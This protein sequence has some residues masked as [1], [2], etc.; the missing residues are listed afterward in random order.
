MTWNSLWPDGTKSVA[1]NTNPGQQ[2][3][4]YIETTLNNDHFFNIGVDEDGHH[5]KVSMEEY[6][7]TAVGAPTDPT[8]PT[9]MDGVFYLKDAN[10][11]IAGFYRNASGIY[12]A[13]PGFISG[14][15]ALTTSYQNVVALPDD[16]YGD[17][18]F[19]I[20]SSAQAMSQGYFKCSGGI[21]QAYCNSQTIGNSNTLTLPMRYGNGDQ[22]SGLNLRVKIQDGTAG[23]YQYRIR[24]WAT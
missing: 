22:V 3:T 19:F 8:I 16:C 15:F 23:T 9:G 12:Q 13:V 14:S 21:C 7:E 11:R 10:G 5:K 17:I 1:Q 2:N 18:H 6:S 4:T 20:A 24:F